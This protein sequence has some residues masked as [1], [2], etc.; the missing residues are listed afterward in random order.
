MGFCLSLQNVLLS[1]L[2]ERRKRK[3]E[4]KERKERESLPPVIPKAVAEMLVIP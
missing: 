1:K 2:E 4:K 3:K